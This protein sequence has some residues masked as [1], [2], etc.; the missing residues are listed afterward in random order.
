MPNH[1][2]TLHTATTREDSARSPIETTGVRLFLVAAAIVAA[3]AIDWFLVPTSYPVAAAYGVPLI[4]AAQLLASP[5]TVAV[6]GG[7]ALALSIGSNILQRAPVAALAANNTGLLAIAL[8]AFLLTRQRKVANTTA[9]E[10]ARLYAEARQHERELATL[11]EISRTVSSTLERRPL[12]GVI[13]D[14]L[15]TV[16]DYSGAGIYL[17]PDTDEYRLHEYRGPLPHENVVGH[18]VSPEAAS[19]IR[20]AMARSEP[21]I[22]EDWGEQTPLMLTAAG[23]ALP[24]GLESIGHGRALLWLPI[25]VRGTIAGAL[26][27]VHQRPGYYTER[28][29]QLAMVFAQQVGSA[30]ENA[31]LYQEAQGKAVLEERQRLARELHGSVSQVLYSIALNAASA[32]ALRARDPERAAAL[33]HDVH[34]LAGVGLAE[35]R[36]LIFELRPESLEQEGLVSALHKQAEAVRARHGVVVHT[37]LGDEPAVPLA[38]K[39]ALYRIAQEALQNVAKHARAQTVDLAL[40]QTESQL[41]LRVH[42]DGRGF[43]PTRTYPGHLGLHSMRERMAGIGGDL[44][45]LSSRGQGTTVCARVPKAASVEPPLHS[46]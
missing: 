26:G 8:L 41:V 36:A 4:L 42:D 27:V 7:V 22:V 34:E 16:V 1:S 14:Q 30:L 12:L 43:N 35:M 39:E 23:V 17:G 45:I 18:R 40:E 3:L 20:E 9:I 46:A 44:D 2:A 24:P 13:L 29:A 6:V 38:A 19:L 33:G 32:V 10:N 21:V 28:H 37:S 11:L 5:R 31:R 15:K 25:I